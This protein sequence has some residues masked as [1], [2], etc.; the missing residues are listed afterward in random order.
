MV[1]AFALGTNTLLCMT[2]YVCTGSRLY[3]ESPAEPHPAPEPS[4]PKPTRGK[5]AKGKGAK[6]RGKK[7]KPGQGGGLVPA[8]AAP[9]WELVASSTDELQA[10]G[11]DLALSS[12]KG[13]S[14][15]GYQVCP[16]G[17]LEQFVKQLVASSIEHMQAAGE[18]LVQ[19]S[20]I[21]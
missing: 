4:P 3:K 13:Q 17:S 8:P 20:M 9:S 19:S 14:D 18:I 7:G 15:I 11:E 16:L 2:A 21:G 10:A 1:I 6:G 5:E 12:I